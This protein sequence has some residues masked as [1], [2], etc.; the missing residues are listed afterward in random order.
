MI[1]EY[2]YEDNVYTANVGVL[3]PEE[4]NHVFIGEQLDKNSLGIGYISVSENGGYIDINV[5]GYSS[6]GK[7]ENFNSD[8]VEMVTQNR[9]YLTADMLEVVPKESKVTILSV[10]YITP[11]GDEVLDNTPIEVHSCSEVRIGYDIVVHTP[12]SHY[13]ESLPEPG[14]GAEGS[15]AV[16]DVPGL[17]TDGNGLPIE[18]LDDLPTLYIGGVNALQDEN[19]LMPVSLKQGLHSLIQYCI[20]YAYEEA[21]LRLEEQNDVW[22]GQGRKVVDYKNHVVIVSNF[23]DSLD[24]APPFDSIVPIEDFSISELINTLQSRLSFPTNVFPQLK[25]LIGFDFKIEYENSEDLVVYNWS[26]D[27]IILRRN[28]YHH[29][30]Y[31]HY[32][33]KLNGG[34]FKE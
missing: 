15:L 26:H 11:E 32:I 4:S 17:G 34:V 8:A 9:P 33:E 25:I 23:S 24:T 7:I 27:I 29:P 19:S 12:D 3:D 1:I 10:Y 16:P 22:E 18:S 28:R 20:D 14:T 2:E 31:F 21:Q 13:P 30:N 5:H 6:T